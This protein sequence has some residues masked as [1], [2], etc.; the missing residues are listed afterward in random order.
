MLAG[1]PQEQEVVASEEA[2]DAGVTGQVLVERDAA[3]RQAGGGVGEEEVEVQAVGQPEERLAA[4]F[5]ADFEEVAETDLAVDGAGGSEQGAE[6]L[7]AGPLVV[8]KR[9]GVRGLLHSQQHAAAEGEHG[10]GQEK[11]GDLFHAPAFSPEAGDPGRHA[12]AR[13]GPGV[14]R[15]DGRRIARMTGLAG[16]PP[17]FR[18]MGNRWSGGVAAL[19]HR[20]QATI[21][22]G[23]KDRVHR[24]IQS[25][26]A[27][28]A[29]LI[30]AD[31]VDFHEGAVDRVGDVA[32]PLDD[33]EA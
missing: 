8:R 24:V 14:K 31:V 4:A 12:I 19:N 5:R 11:D 18:F 16:T 9:S 23:S 29:R 26:R 10:G 33:G 21:P 28:V 2:V 15:I 6:R 13:G 25:R 22:S 1:D 30:D 7:E 27:S 17:G 3:Q 32:G 20:L